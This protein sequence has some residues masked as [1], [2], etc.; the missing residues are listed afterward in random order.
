MKP[1]SKANDDNEDL[2]EGFTNE[3]KEAIRNLSQE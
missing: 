3:E 1:A 2:E